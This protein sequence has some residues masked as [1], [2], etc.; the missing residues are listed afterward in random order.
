VA[1]AVADVGVGDWLQA[2]IRLL[3]SNRR[4]RFNM[5]RIPS[6]G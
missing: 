2:I 1:V 6:L 5:V 4:V 3:L